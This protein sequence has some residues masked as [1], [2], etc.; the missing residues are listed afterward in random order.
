[1][2]ANREV[3]ATFAQDTADNDGDGLTNYAELV[4]HS[5]DPNDSDSDDD[6][7]DDSLEVQIGLDPSTANANLV[8]F[9]NNRESTARSEGNT[10]GIAYA[11]NYSSFSLYTEAEKNA[12]NTVQ[13]NLGRTAGIVEGNAS[14]IALVC[15]NP[16]TFS[17]YE[18]EKNASIE[19]ANSEGK[20]CREELKDYPPSHTWIKWAGQNHTQMNGFTNLV[21]D[22]CGPVRAFFR[23]FINSKLGRVGEPGFIFIVSRRPFTIMGLKLGFLRKDEFFRTYDLLENQSSKSG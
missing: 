23:L 18:A 22:G 17:L 14:G 16:N 1:M 9:F 4:T 12:S 2:G 15:A 13:Y 10:S 3:N 21:W 19:S 5:S 8:T 7:L 11:V 20:N 6:S